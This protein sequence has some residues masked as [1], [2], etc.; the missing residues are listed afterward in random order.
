MKSPALH[1]LSVL[2]MSAVSAVAAG[3]VDYLRDVK[4]L[5]EHK[6]YA[7]HGALKQQ[8]GL[9][10]DTAV[11][12]AVGGESGA[13]VIAGR[14]SDSLLID[15]LTGDAGFRMPP[16][17]EGS[18]MT[19]KEIDLIRAWIADG[20]HGPVDEQP[21]MDPASWWSY[22]EL[23]RPEL[24]D[25]TETDWCRND[26]DYFVAAARETN[27]LPHVVET[28]KAAWLRRVSLD[29]I[30]LPPTR[31]ELH[32]FLATDS[33]AAYENVVDELLNRPQYG[34]RW[35]RHWMDV[36]RYSDWYGSRG[37]NE[38]RY[39]QR[40]IWRWRDWIVDSLNADKG[41]DQMI[42]EMLAADEISGGD[43]AVLPATGYLGRNWYKFDRN[44]WMFETVER[45][46]EAFLG[47]TFR[48]CRCH[49]HKFDP[50]SQEEYYRFRAFFEPHDVRTDR[51]S[52][53]TATQKDA[54]LG[55]VLSDGIALAYDKHPAVPTYRFER[56]DNRYPDESKLLTP[57][58][59][60]SLGG[61]V[62]ISEINLPAETWFPMLRP[63]VR[64]TLITKAQN[65]VSAAETQ[66][67]ERQTA[68]KVASEK[69]AAVINTESASSPEPETFLHDTF[70]AAAPKSWETIN[71]TW[72]YDDGKLL[73][74][75][76]TSFATMVS[77]EN[78]PRDFHVHLRYRPLSPGTYRSVGFSFDYQG[79]GDSQDVYTSTGDDRQSVQA[80]HRVGGKQVY[81]KQ[82]IVAT[83]LTVGEEAVLEV[84]VQ[85]SKLT[86]DLNGKRKLDYVMP[87]ERRD[88]RFALWVHQ[89]AA[90]FLELKITRQVDSLETLEQRQRDAGRAV[91]LAQAELNLAHGE[92]ES[93][94]RRL[95]ADIATH[96]ESDEQSAQQSAREA[97]AAELAVAVLQAE[98]D[99]LKA[100]ASDDKRDA[101]K[102]K[103]TT[104]REAAKNPGQS[105]AAVG[106]QF[107]KTSTGRRSAL[108]HWITRPENPRTA[109]VA[110]NHLWGRHFG[111]PLVATP[112][113]FGLN[114]RKPTHPEL[115]NWLAT[116]LIHDDW[117]MKPLH[118]RIV[119][120][121]TYRMATLA[122]SS[123]IS[124]DRDPKNQF[125]WRMNSRRMEA[126]VVRDSS[127]FLASRLDMTI[128]GP[129]ISEKDGEKTLRR[130][131]YFRNTP[132]EK[133]AMLE[134]FDVADPNSCYRRKESVVPHQ[135]LA[136][137]NS[138][139]TLD[140]ART[141][142][143]Q[144]ANEA[145]FV[146]AAFE[147]VLSRTPTT[148]E[149]ARCRTFLAEHT[150]LLQEAPT[151][152]FAAG[153]S[154]TRA[155]STDPSMR[156][157]ENLVHVLFLHNDF[158]TI[159]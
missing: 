96:M 141:I 110:A 151:E 43:P 99:V 140:S 16:A 76:V 66:L 71:G 78:H 101:A 52:A 154:A 84:S 53:L 139:L 12:L 128:G 70:S 19:D 36:W 125:L 63:A 37:I 14:S 127:L 91:R 77:E 129:E 131:L 47:L 83:P 111:Q 31:Q 103:L 18:P 1:L 106:E 134:V 81:P 102:A 104:A 118:R 90:E 46:G 56:G 82:G 11:S 42:R 135:S 88:G 27:E 45:T 119:L 158:V 4:P 34:E 86:I 48:C 30:G 35:G 25:V 22:Q 40:H 122:G 21:Q 108:A 65:L 145:D 146:T 49:D 124:Q 67:Q 132:N 13:V 75:A 39:S 92:A 115:L 74:T 116:Q 105:Y 144:L 58:V 97:S 60:A 38:I 24:P 7:C 149:A 73:Q 94:R 152:Q 54:T 33:P 123:D 100:G 44:V 23:T 57:G 148:D 138:G 51:I 98:V 32:R 95:A 136:M 142:A 117:K 143:G 41:Y 157:K 9:R 137:M 150:G 121:A 153:G 93:I 109:R 85:G 126:E 2:L 120:S 156:A 155:P 133:M 26:I 64:E 114:G 72:T 5:L 28:S 3:E 69:L 130:S 6:C 59:P 15:V 17:N 79:K 113:N 112:E 29:L 68:V 50:I 10:L 87:V 61:E 55:Q 8:G 159:R 89:G 62:H 20:A 147:T 80:F 107:P